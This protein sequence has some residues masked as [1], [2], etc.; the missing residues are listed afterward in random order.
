MTSL[1]ATR[2]QRFAKVTFPTAIKDSFTGFK[3]AT[4]FSSTACIGFEYVGG[5]EGLGSRIITYSQY[6]RTTESFAC[7]FYVIIIGLFM[8]GMVSLI[9]KKVVKWQV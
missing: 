5:N 6:L 2:I 7:I 8:Y 9:E 1:G 3:L 4:I